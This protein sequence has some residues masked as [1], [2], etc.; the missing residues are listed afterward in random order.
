VRDLDVVQIGG[1][2]ENK[3]AL[4]T[5][6]VVTNTGINAGFA[7]VRGSWTI[8]GEGAQI[9]CLTTP[10]GRCT[11]GSGK[12]PAAAFTTFTVTGVTHPTFNYNPWDNSDPEGDSNGTTITIILQ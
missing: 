1:P 12:I 11:V 5:I 6:H 8:S 3:E 4:V 2:S 9:T 7:T 10:S